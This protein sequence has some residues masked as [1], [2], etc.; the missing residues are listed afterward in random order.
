METLQVF[1]RKELLEREIIQTKNAI[2]SW[3]IQNKY[4][5]Q[6]VLVGKANQQF[7]L[8]VARA[9]GQLK[10]NEEFLKFLERELVDEDKNPSPVEG[11]IV[12]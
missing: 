10:A 5:A 7:M 9:Q 11:K 2:L 6:K 4:L 12:E 8:E 3:Q 1:T